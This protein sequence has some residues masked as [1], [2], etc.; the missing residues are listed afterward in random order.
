MLMVFALLVLMLIAFALVAA[1]MMAF[2]RGGKPPAEP[3]SPAARQALDKI[4][5]LAG[6]LAVDMVDHAQEVEQITSVLKAIPADDEAALAAVSRLVQINQQIQQQLASTEEKLQTQ[7]RQMEAQ[8]FEARTDALTQ[9]ANRRSFDDALARRIEE[10]QRRGLDSCIVLL[11]VDYFKKF[12]D[13]HGHQAGDEVLRHVAQVLRQNVTEEDLVARYGG[14][15]FAIVCPTVMATA[16]TAADRARAAI[17]AA[18]LR[19]EGRELRVTA[20]AGI[21]ELQPGEDQAAL[22]KRAD[23][24]LYA[25]K[26]GGRNCLYWNDGY[27]NHLFRSNPKT[28][29]HSAAR[30]DLSELLGG[31]WTDNTGE[32]PEKVCSATAVYVSSKPAF[33]DD[34]IRRLAQWKR[35]Q[36]PLCLML[37]QIDDFADG[38]RKRGEEAASLALRV[39]AQLLKANMRDMDHVS[40]LGSDTFALLLPAAQLEDGARCAERVHRAAQQCRLPSRAKGFSLS[41]TIGVVETIA[42]DDMRRLLQ[43][44]RNALQVAIDRGRGSIYAQDI[45]GTLART[46]LAAHA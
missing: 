29:P 8:A 20:S 7:A 22:I 46:R 41:L 24:A 25:A 18:T 43:R 38:V 10:Q 30:D 19:Y 34:L 4:Q 33:I 11:D 14:E 39:T 44:G 28:V 40:R 9:I 27:Q 26:K 35:D 42:G 32:V 12:N 2:A 1:A 6:N 5:N 17:S 31:E 3:M 15:E 37:V 23:A 21:A 45:H 16:R 36:T 13:S